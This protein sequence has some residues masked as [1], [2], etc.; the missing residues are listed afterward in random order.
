MGEW[1]ANPSLLQ[2][3]STFISSQV[4][5][6]RHHAPGGIGRRGAMQSE[7]EREES[8]EEIIENIIGDQKD[9]P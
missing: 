1:R 3:D 7:Q 8:S 4:T 6:E 9:F 5:R 2:W